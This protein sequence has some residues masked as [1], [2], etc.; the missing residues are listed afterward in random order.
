[1]REPSCHYNLKRKTD[2]YIPA[3]EIKHNQ[4]TGPAPKGKIPMDLPLPDLMKR[5]LR[6]TGVSIVMI[7]SFFI[8]LGQWIIT[9][10]IGYAWITAHLVVLTLS[11]SMWLYL[12]S[13][14]YPFSEPC[15]NICS[16]W[17]KFNK[18]GD[19]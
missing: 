17:E 6:I 1:L 7:L 18:D 3:E 4:K 19:Y 16:P 14:T 10:N 12:L 5:K 11:I 15:Q 9:K 2:A 13:G 8:V